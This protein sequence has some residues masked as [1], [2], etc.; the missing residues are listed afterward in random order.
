MQK[1][2]L[3]FNKLR[4]ILDDDPT[5]EVPVLDLGSYVPPE[6]LELDDLADTGQHQRLDPASGPPT[7]ASPADSESA[8]LADSGR[9]LL[10]LEG[11]IADLQGKW[12]GV[13]DEILGRDQ[14]IAGL[15]AQLVARSEAIEALEAELQRVSAIVGSL[16]TSRDSLSDE[17]RSRDKAIKRQRAEI[18][19]RDEKFDA[20]REEM[21]ALRAELA[22]SQQEAQRLEQLVQERDGEDAGKAAQMELLELK[23]AEQRLRNQD[24]EIYLDGSNSQRQVLADELSRKTRELS[25]RERGDRTWEKNSLRQEKEISRLQEAVARLERRCET[26]RRSA[27]ANDS[28]RL[29]MADELDAARD[30]IAELGRQRLEAGE[31]LVA[32]EDELEARCQEIA[33]LTAKSAQIEQSSAALLAAEAKLDFLNETLAA[34][35]EQLGDADDTNELAHRERNELAA[36]LSEREI[37]VSNL[38]EE[39]ENARRRTEE[40]KATLADQA[41]RIETLEE[42]LTS[43]DEALGALRGNMDRLNALESSL[44]ALDIRMQSPAAVGDTDIDGDVT[45]LMIAVGDARAV[46]YPLHKANMIIG[47]APDS[48]IQIRHKY[49]SRH[50]A[51]LTNDNGDTFIE[52][53]GSTNGVRVNATPIQRRHLLHNGDLV[54][55]GQKQ[56]QFIDLMAP[57][58]GQGNA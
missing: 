6:S 22:T 28:D 3:E 20:M 2:K 54:D 9:A 26:L 56:F 17:L 24:L 29:T 25:A 10:R 37:Q 27:T 44:Q 43:R 52:D 41:L 40:L 12:A 16:E 38:T 11:E 4:D 33:A 18:A 36:A 50:H 48:D 47:R 53:L 46:K 13:H 34:R 42:E 19:A 51:R 31:K 49:I 57:H 8:L 21:N 35:D 1:E 45:R 5:D 7:E 58:V 30:Q 55:I 39:L 23:L 15:K 32:V 14:E